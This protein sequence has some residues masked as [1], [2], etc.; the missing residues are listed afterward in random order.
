MDLGQVDV[1]DEEDPDQAESHDCGS[2]DQHPP[3]RVRVGILNADSLRGAPLIGELGVETAVNVDEALQGI[4]RQESLK[5]L[6]ECVGPDGARDRVSNRASDVAHNI[7]QCE[8]CGDVLMVGGGEDGQLF[9]E[10]DDAS[11]DGQE[12]LAHDKIADVAVGLAEIDQQALR[13]DV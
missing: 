13:K 12:D 10:D 4:F 7:E 2:G 11:A 1:P 6:A 8:K 3:L 5:R 9:T